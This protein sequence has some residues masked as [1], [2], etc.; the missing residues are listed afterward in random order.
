[1]FPL[2]GTTSASAVNVGSSGGGLIVPHIHVPPELSQEL[3]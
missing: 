1:M 3:V 2:V